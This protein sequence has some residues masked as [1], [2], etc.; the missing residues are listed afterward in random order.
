M[1][2]NKTLLTLAIGTC[3]IGAYAQDVIVK[4]DGST[5][6]SKVLEVNTNDIKYKKFSNQNGPIYSIEKKELI[7][8]NYENGEKDIFDCNNP[9]DSEKKVSESSN[10]PRLIARPA[11]TRN[12]DLIS[13]YNRYY[14]PTD[15]IGKSKRKAKRVLLIIGMKESSVVS[16]GE[17]EIQMLTNK[18]EGPY[19]DYWCQTLNIVNKTNRTIYIDKGNCFRISSDSPLYCYYDTSEQTTIS[20]G[21]GSGASIGL[22]AISSALGIGGI[23][24][25]IASG[26][27][28]GGGRSSSVSTTYSQQRVIAIPA[29]SSR[30]LTN[31]K[32]VLINRNTNKH[33]LM[34]SLERFHFKDIKTSQ[35]GLHPKQLSIGE[36]QV[37]GEN[38]LPWNRKYIITY[39]TN[40]Q[41][42]TYSTLEAD[43]YIQ[44][45]IGV[46]SLKSPLNYRPDLGG[47]VEEE[48]DINTYVK[49][50]ND[51]TIIGYHRL[52]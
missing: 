10:V 51:H 40:E 17:V 46:P 26:V 37:F 6:L 16:N 27:S 47:L 33:E 25:Q 23:A 18:H 5:I 15:V 48:L 34:E 24:G 30:A 41:F 19:Y 45:I 12:A 35:I 52:E 44:E 36:V 29:N 13:L 39:S 20:S 4:K 31:D 43:F 7:S 21:V 14:E 1:K 9:S 22:G 11:D 8:I 32:W 2:L 28:L 42:T 38:D 50:F 49:D 3:G